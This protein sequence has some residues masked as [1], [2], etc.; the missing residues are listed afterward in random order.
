[1]NTF[2]F[3]IDGMLMKNVIVVIFPDAIGEGWRAVIVWDI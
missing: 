1:V 3:N 2:E